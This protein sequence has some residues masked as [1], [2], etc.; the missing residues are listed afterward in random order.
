MP[1]AINEDCIACGNCSVVC[2][3]EAI[4][5]GYTYKAVGELASP[6]GV[7]EDGNM[8][9][10]R[11]SVWQGYRITGACTECGACEQVCP[12]GAILKA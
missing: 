3:Q 5:D 9:N 11:S 8:N 2:P 12:V 7:V 10:R 1:Y 6:A 4:D